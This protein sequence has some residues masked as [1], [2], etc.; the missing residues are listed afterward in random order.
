MS[1]MFKCVMFLAANIRLYTG[2]VGVW[3]VQ[4]CMCILE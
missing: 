1:V 2:T 3:W 4:A